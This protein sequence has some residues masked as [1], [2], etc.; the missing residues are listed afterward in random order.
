M[1][2]SKQLRFRLLH[3]FRPADCFRALRYRCATRRRRLTNC[4]NARE[5]AISLHEALVLPPELTAKPRGQRALESAGTVTCIDGRGI[6]KFVAVL[7]T[8]GRSLTSESSSASHP[9]GTAF[10]RISSCAQLRAGLL[11][12]ASACRRFVWFVELAAVPQLQFHLQAAQLAN[13]AVS[14]VRFGLRAAFQTGVAE[15][16]G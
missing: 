5:T 16:V 10:N 8:F 2:P 4:S 3:H 11:P 14:I 12:V 6:A 15:E 9:S 1:P 7:A 13:G